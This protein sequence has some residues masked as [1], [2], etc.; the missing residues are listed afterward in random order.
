MA[1]APGSDRA[2]IGAGHPSFRLKSQTAEPLHFEPFAMRRGG[3]PHKHG[4]AAGAAHHESH[5]RAV[6]A[7]LRIAGA[8]SEYPP[9]P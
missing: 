6:K 1:N 5:R 4:V 7:Q 3:K 9:K 2:A 8:P